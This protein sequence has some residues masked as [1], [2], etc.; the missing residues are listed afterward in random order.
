MEIRGRGALLASLA[1]L[2]CAAPPASAQYLDPT[3]PWPQL[4]PARPTTDGTQ[5]G[6]VPGCERAS[7]KC[8]ERAIRRMRAFR[9]RFGCD[10]RAVFAATYLI[11]TET[12]R[13]TLRE[14]PDFFDDRDW[15]ISEDALFADYY[16]RALEADLAG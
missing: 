14:Q 13:Q 12:V 5:P 3:P 16:F 7:P 2:A 11:V 6:P 9:D 15:L 8:V 1:A 4:L 10:H